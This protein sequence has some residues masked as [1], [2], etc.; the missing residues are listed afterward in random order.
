M[1]RFAINEISTQPA[2]TKP[3]P[4]VAGRRSRPRTRSEMG[5]QS[6]ERTRAMIQS[7]M[8]ISL[9]QRIATGEKEAQPHQV[10]AALGLLRKVLP[11]LQATLLSGD[12]QL[13][14][15]VSVRLL[16]D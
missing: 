1:E 3:L 14:I 15:T 10:T 9:L 16:D 11:D 4:V 8:L 2:G 5:K 12:P 7:G 13:P 6:A